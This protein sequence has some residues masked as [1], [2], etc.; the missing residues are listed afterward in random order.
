[1]AFKNRIGIT[2]EPNS[3]KIKHIWKVQ[4]TLIYHIADKYMYTEVDGYLLLQ[5]C[6]IHLQFYEILS[7][8]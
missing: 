5:N 4:C 2:L 6:F 8:L 3:N 7:L 1:M